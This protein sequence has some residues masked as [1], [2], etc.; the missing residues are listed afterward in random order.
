MLELMIQRHVSRTLL[1]PVDAR[2]PSRILS[3]RY[4]FGGACPKD[5]L[6]AEKAQ[7]PLAAGARFGYHDEHDNMFATTRLAFEARLQLTVSWS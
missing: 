1:E 7:K 6:W 2:A 4:Q 5:E 3:R